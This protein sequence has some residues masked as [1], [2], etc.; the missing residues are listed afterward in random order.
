MLTTIFTALSGSI[1]SFAGY[2]YYT[3]FKNKTQNKQLELDLKN[4]KSKLFNTNEISNLMDNLQDDLTI[5]YLDSLLEECKNKKHMNIYIN[6]FTNTPSFDSLFSLILFLHEN[7][8]MKKNYYLFVLEILILHNDLITSE[9]QVIQLINLWYMNCNYSLNNKYNNTSKYLALSAVQLLKNYNKTN[10]NEMESRII[11]SI[12]FDREIFIL[13]PQI[14][15]FTLYILDNNLMI[16]QKYHNLDINEL[17]SYINGKLQNT[18]ELPS[19]VLDLISF[20]LNSHGENKEKSAKILLEYFFEL[21]NYEHFLYKYFNLNIYTVFL[22]QLIKIN[23]VNLTTFILII[24]KHLLDNQVG[25]AQLIYVNIIKNQR[26]RLFEDDKYNLKLEEKALNRGYINDP[27][28][29]KLE[30]W[31]KIK[32]EDDKIAE[33]SFKL[34]LIDINDLKTWYNNDKEKIFTPYV[35]GSYYLSRR[36]FYSA[37]IWLN[38]AVKNGNENAQNKLD[39]SKLLINY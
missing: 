37:T 22:E 5:K 23:N 11:S 36:D 26:I 4:V 38:R 13:Y 29:K 10:I 27:Y 34:N 17:Y 31:S 16:R 19:H 39:I 7:E 3:Y 18:R 15:Y 28:V 9:D 12:G 33:I 30:L 21:T 35:I 14:L 1:I 32:E 6:E 25:K 8:F 20:Y 2:Q 24:L